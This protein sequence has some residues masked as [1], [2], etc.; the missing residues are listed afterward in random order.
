MGVGSVV[1]LFLMG[2]VVPRF[3]TV[4]QGS[5][6][7]LPIASQWL[8]LWGQW[9]SDNRGVVFITLLTAIAV[10]GW[11]IRHVI[12]KFGW[13]RLLQWLPGAAPRLRVL[14]LSRLYLSMGMLIEGGISITRAME[15]ARA[16]LPQAS[17]ADLSAAQSEVSQG[18]SLSMSL[19]NHGLATPVA[20]RL[21]RV[22]E[23]TGQLGTMLSRAAAFYDN[24]TQRWIERFTKAFEP[25]LMAA[26]GI[27]IGLIV[28]LLYMPIFDLAG[29]L[30]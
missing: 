24:E 29:S 30:Q 13:M 5:G 17:Q 3:A 20:L 2:Y 9:V 23:Q 8:L 4:Y 12:L 6:R 27:V 22:G 19:E 7:P 10:A 21:I 18:N 26:I 25:I 14:E 1:A 11:S 15:L 28:I 16:V